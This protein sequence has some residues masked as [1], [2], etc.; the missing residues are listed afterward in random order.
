MPQRSGGGRKA[1]AGCEGAFA[2]S[3]QQLGA[4]S[5]CHK[6]VPALP[7]APGA[8]V[9]DLLSA[10]LGLSGGYVRA[11]LLAAPGGQ[12]LGYEI[13]SARGQLEPALQEM[14]GRMLPIW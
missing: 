9:D 10:F 14:A 6:C 4:R 3:R 11:K 13:T 8:V 2:A 1:V 5:A 12:R 7:H